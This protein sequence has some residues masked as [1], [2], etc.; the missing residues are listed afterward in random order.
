MGG[1]LGAER[2]GQAQG[3]PSAK[4]RMVSAGMLLCYLCGPVVSWPLVDPSPRPYSLA[5]P[6]LRSTELVRMVLNG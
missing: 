1:E 4:P 2:T 5:H 6:S 3:G